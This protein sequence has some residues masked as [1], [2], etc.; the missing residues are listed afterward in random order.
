MVEH[1]AQLLSPS[2][3]RLDRSG[4]VFIKQNHTYMWQKKGYKSTNRLK[5]VTTEYERIYEGPAPDQP[6]LLSDSVERSLIQ[7]S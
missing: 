4:Q 6:L 2:T 3:G 1:S 7:A 5:R